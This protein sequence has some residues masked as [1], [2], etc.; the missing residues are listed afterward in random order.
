MGD[1]RESLSESDRTLSEKVGSRRQLANKLS[2]PVVWKVMLREI[3]DRTGI[4]T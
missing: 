1:L 3:E 2:K 4:S